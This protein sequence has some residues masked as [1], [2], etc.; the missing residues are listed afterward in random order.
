LLKGPEAE[1]SHLPA[2]GQLW[3]LWPGPL[4]LGAAQDPQVLDQSERGGGKAR[5]PIT[6]RGGMTRAI[7]KNP[8]ELRQKKNCKTPMNR[9]PPYDRAMKWAHLGNNENVYCNLNE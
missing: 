8:P 3:T 4:H 5:R 1:E 2:D 7:D 9:F 6:T